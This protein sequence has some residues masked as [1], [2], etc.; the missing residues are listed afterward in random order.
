MMK[1]SNK[2]SGISRRTAIQSVLGVVGLGMALPK[3]SYA[4]GSEAR[5]MQY[6]DKV[7][8][9]SLKLFLSSLGGFF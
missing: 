1:S 9:T 5:P 7:K 6:K 2:E 3:S 4:Y 8:I